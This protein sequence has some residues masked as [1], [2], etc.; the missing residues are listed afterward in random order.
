MTIKEIMK[1]AV[2]SKAVA[3]LNLLV[4]KDSKEL[5]YEETG[6]ANIENNKPYTRDTIA[7]L[8]SMTKPITGAACMLLVERG[9]LD[10]NA[11][12]DRYLP[13]FKDV[14]V[15]NGDFSHTAKRNP[16]IRE[17]M[18]MTGGFT[19]G[20]SLTEPGRRTDKLLLDAE[21]KLGTSEE[22]ST[23]DIA[24]GLAEAGLIYDPGT[25]WAYSTAADVMGA[26]IEA[27]TGMRFG[28]FLK[29]EFFEPLEMNDTDFYVPEDKRNRL[30]D[31][32]DVVNGEFSLY[33]TNNLDIKYEMD[34]RPAYEAGGAGLASTIDDYSH[35]ASM[36]LQNGSY[37]GKQILKP[38]TVEFFTKPNLLSWQQ[39]YM[40]ANYPFWA[41]LT[42]ANFMRRV[43]DPS[44]CGHLSFM[45]EYGWDGWLGCYFSN[46]PSKN[47]T[48]LL[49][50][51]RRDAGT[52]ETTRRI[53]NV[54]ADLL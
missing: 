35:F 49:T 10:L 47:A 2:D 4:I 51:Q 40:W 24:K 32:Y 26:V 9:L 50:M 23:M 33:H 3:G 20:D 21:K 53:R 7:R 31:A 5:I 12:L 17:V 27:V 14:K 30:A 8:Y 46:I 19:Y 36:L 39:E 25:K 48:I 15:Y 18:A 34:K 41:G 37:K 29:K 38:S 22:V 16:L 42:Y 52:C 28:D 1:D 43:I 44:L 54:L 11:S 45:D 13:F 6:F